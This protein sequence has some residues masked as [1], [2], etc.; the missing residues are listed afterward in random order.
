[1]EGDE[2]RLFQQTLEGRTVLTAGDSLDL[3]SNAFTGVVEN[4]HTEPM[5]RLARR[6]HGFDGFERQ[7]QQFGAHTHENLAAERP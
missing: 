6:L 3:G 5:V 1:M 4:P 7:S 2:V